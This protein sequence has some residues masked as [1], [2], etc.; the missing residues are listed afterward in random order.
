MDTFYSI[1]KFDFLHL[2]MS[3]DEDGQPHITKFEFRSKVLSYCTQAGHLLTAFSSIHQ[4]S[5][6]IS[7]FI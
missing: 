1:L 2:E 6:S 4:Q 7:Q 3:N 5:F